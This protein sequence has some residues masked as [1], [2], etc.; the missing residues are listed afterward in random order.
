MFRPMP[1]VL[2]ACLILSSPIAFG[3]VSDED[4]AALRADLVALTQR[5]DALAA[6]NAELKAQAHLAPPFSTQVRASI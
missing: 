4:F 1:V 2:L 3:A 6:E 5:L